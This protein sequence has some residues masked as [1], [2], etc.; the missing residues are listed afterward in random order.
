MADAQAA[1]DA[2]PRGD[3][4][5]APLARALLARILLERSEPMAA[6][7]LLDLVDGDT[8]WTGRVVFAAVL[9]A[10]GWM[11]LTEGEAAEA[12]ATFLECGRR[13]AAARTPNP[14]VR[15][16]RSGAA[17]A[18]SMLDDPERAARL[19]EEEIELARAFGAPGTLGAA[20]RTSGVVARGDDALDRLREAV[21]VL[22]TSPAELEYAR[23]LADLGGALRR[24]GK[25][26]EA[27]DVLRRAL[28][29]AHRCGALA[30]GE[31]ARSEL[32]AAGARPRRAALT[33]F[34][35]LT[36]GERRVAELAAGGLTNREIAQAL[37][38]T[39]KTVEWH[40]GNTYGKLG[41]SS[42]RELKSLN[43]ELTAC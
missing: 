23:A 18:A 4:P 5:V 20:L 10:R 24:A 14:A 32:T 16:W 30:T 38:V 2:L 6:R 41:I 3:E 7:E 37:F 29:L 11:A 19:A 8:P 27:Q 36:A 31:R 43:D 34:E 25:R 39:V 22:E 28:D 35:A 15:A 26:S 21:S 9:E 40:L 12:L 1:L 42:R 13:Q 33:G 17:L